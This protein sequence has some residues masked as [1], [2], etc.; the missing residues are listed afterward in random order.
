MR[1]LP[2]GSTTCGRRRGESPRVAGRAYRVEAVAVHQVGSYPPS[3][4]GG[5]KGRWTQADVSKL[6]QTGLT[7][8]GRHLDAPMPEYRMNSSDAD[9]VAAYIYSL[10][11]PAKSTQSAEQPVTPCALAAVRHAAICT[12]QASSCDVRFRTAQMGASLCTGTDKHEFQSTSWTS[13]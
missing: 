8:R 13:Y 4:V 3:L 1:R 5:P 2:Y 6:L 12:Q 9:A 7:A 11:K 10:P